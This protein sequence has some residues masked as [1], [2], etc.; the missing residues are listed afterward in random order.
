MEMIQQDMEMSH[1]I[2]QIYELVVTILLTHD[3]SQYV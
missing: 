2:S 3:E 1:V